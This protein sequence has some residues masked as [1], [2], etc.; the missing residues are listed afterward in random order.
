MIREYAQL[1]QESAYGV[2]VATP[3][4]GTDQICIRLP[5]PN[6]QTMRPN[7]IVQPVPYGG[8]FNIIKDSVSDKTELKGTLTTPLFYSQSK[9][10]LGWALDRNNGTL[11]WITTEP[12][13]QFASVTL[14]HAIM[15]DTGTW[16]RKR[17]TGVKCD[18]FKFNMSDEAQYATVSFDIMGGTYQ[19]N[20]FDSSADPTVTVFPIPVDADFP[21]DFVLWIHTHGGFTLGAGL[22]AQYSSLGLTAQHQH[23]VRYYAN[24]FVQVMR[25]FG[26][27]FEID[28]DLTLLMTPD[29]RGAHDTLAPVT[30][31][32]VITDGTHTI[33][34]NLF[35][36]NRIKGLDDD[37]QLAKLYGRKLSLENRYDGT[38]GNWFAL[39]VAP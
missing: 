39:T 15:D 32:L 26:S 5:G 25:S 31:Q 34:F 3:T 27:A 19:G 4:R 38:A 22:R 36:N 17:Y 13:Q 14:D 7:P 10:L 29:D 9:F 24:R 23:D 6:Q 1:T 33:T 12:L 2:A 30:A 28:A 8:G 35:T 11:P 20:T 21:A 37:T 18:G 16:K